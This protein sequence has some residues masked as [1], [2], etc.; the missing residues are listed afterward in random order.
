[1]GTKGIIKPIF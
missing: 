1:M